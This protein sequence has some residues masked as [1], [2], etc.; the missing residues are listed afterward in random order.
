MNIEILDNTLSFDVS[1]RTYRNAIINII[2]NL[3]PITALEIGTHIFQTSACFPY[4]WSKMGIWGKLITCDIGLHDRDSTPPNMV[5]PIM[6]YPYHK[7][8]YSRIGNLEVYYKDWQEQDFNSRCGILDK[9]VTI[10][11][12]KMEELDICEFD[13]TFVDGDHCREAI[14]KDLALAK[15]LTSLNGYILIDDIA[16]NNHP[17]LVEF[18]RGLKDHNDFYEITGMGLIKCGDLRL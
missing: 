2:L 18:Y 12:N 10:I 1:P 14:E 13:L 7:D 15:S 16:D 5:Y 11:S 3:R 6:V 9:N 4:A 8:I 17:E